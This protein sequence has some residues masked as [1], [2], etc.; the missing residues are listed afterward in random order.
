MAEAKSREPVHRRVATRVGCNVAAKISFNGVGLCDA[1]IKD[2]STTGLRLFVPGRG[3]LP[4]EFQVETAMIGR[5]LNVRV[6]WT[7]GDMLGVEF[8]FNRKHG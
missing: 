2:I 6:H 7:D 8:I 3:W 4:S 1:I 5:P